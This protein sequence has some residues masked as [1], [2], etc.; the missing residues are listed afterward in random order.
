M[1]RIVRGIGRGLESAFRAVRDA[2]MPSYKLM[3]EMGKNKSDNG[4]EPTSSG[5]LATPSTKDA[6]ENITPVSSDLTNTGSDNGGDE[7][8]TTP[9]QD[10]PA[11]DRLEDPSTSGL[12]EI[13]VD[14]PT[15][16]TNPLEKEEED[17]LR[18]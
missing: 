1:S 3:K 17:F 13:A 16:I 4:F 14:I 9:I 18:V 12:G 2:V 7:N 6:N 15:D 8:I 10:V 5:D 11:T